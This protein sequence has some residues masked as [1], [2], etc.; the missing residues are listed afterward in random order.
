MI[1]YQQFTINKKCQNNGIFNS[2]QVKTHDYSYKIKI[3][4]KL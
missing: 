3:V 2:F 1:L 4:I